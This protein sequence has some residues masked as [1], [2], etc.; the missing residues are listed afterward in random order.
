M[1][2]VGESDLVAKSLPLRKNKFVEKSINGDI[3]GIAL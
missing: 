1:S 3:N 2:Y